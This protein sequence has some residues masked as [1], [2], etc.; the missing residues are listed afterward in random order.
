[1][2]ETP[3]P[4][5]L[6]QNS[7]L[8][9][10]DIAE[11]LEAV[12][13]AGLEEGQTNQ[14]GQLDPELVLV[15]LGWLRKNL[16]PKLAPQ[17]RREV[18]DTKHDFATA[19]YTLQLQAEREQMR[20]ELT[21]QEQAEREVATETAQAKAMKRAEQQARQ[22]EHQ[23]QLQIA[24]DRVRDS[25]PEL[26]FASVLGMS[27]E[28]EL[29]QESGG[30]VVSSR[31]GFQA[32]LAERAKGFLQEPQEL[33]NDLKVIRLL[34]E[35]NSDTHG[36]V[37][38]AY[39][40]EIASAID[41]ALAASHYDLKDF[42]PEIVAKWFNLASDAQT[43][44][45]IN[46][47]SQNVYLKEVTD[48]AWVDFLER[49]PV[50]GHGQQ[51]LTNTLETVVHQ[52]PSQL[53]DTMYMIAEKGLEPQ[54]PIRRRM[55]LN[56]L[57]ACLDKELLAASILF[58]QTSA[59]N[60]KEPQQKALDLQLTLQWLGLSDSLLGSGRPTSEAGEH[61]SDEDVSV[62]KKLFPYELSELAKEGSR[63]RSKRLDNIRDTS[64]EVFARWVTET[65]EGNSTTIYGRFMPKL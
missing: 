54:D 42:S 33:V 43:E 55:T 27:E 45:A 49:N 24:I 48:A 25:N 58:L 57:G 63:S 61:L 28:L 9:R 38:V 3:G 23:T 56:I 19:E 64:T 4:I 37:V 47:T 11:A 62:L 53:L 10:P 32:K 20:L 17:L 59:A 39:T 44:W 8:A 5:N 31:R 52:Y 35:G 50:V 6:A 14:P 51:I 29:C 13:I 15:G 40:R 41:L 1:M 21:R 22:I 30:F 26:N 60:D 18:I 7:L 16:D 46:S 65:S 36:G 12:Y 34:N 2:S